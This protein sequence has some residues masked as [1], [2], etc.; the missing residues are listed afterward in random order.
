MKKIIRAILFPPTIYRCIFG[1]FSLLAAG[2]VFLFGWYDHPASYVVYCA[3]AL[4]LYYII[5]CT[6]LPAIK[7]LK[8]V[9]IRNR[10]IRRYYEDPIFNSRVILYRGLLINILYAFF[11][12]IT[13]VYYRSTWMIAIS[14]YYFTLIILKGRLVQQ[15]I[16]FMKEDGNAKRAAQWRSYRMTGWLLLLLNVALSGIVVHVV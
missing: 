2:L 3:S 1:I 10:Y 15:D 11:K 5:T 6:L 12:L 13:G 16:R 9:L 8:K 7:E 14:V 4:G